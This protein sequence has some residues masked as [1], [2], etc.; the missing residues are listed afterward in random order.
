MACKE[1]ATCSHMTEPERPV[2]TGSIERMS[3]LVGDRASATFSITRRNVSPTATGL[4]LPF[5][6]LRGK[7]RAEQKVEDYLGIEV[8]MQGSGRKAF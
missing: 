4:A 8:T 1:R 2:Y 3:S 5:F 7:R 6:F